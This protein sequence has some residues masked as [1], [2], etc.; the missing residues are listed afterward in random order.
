MVPPCVRC[1]SLNLACCTPVYAINPTYSLG[2]ILAPQIKE[3][4]HLSIPLSGY[5]CAWF[6][7]YDN[8]SCPL[9]QGFPIVATIDGFNPEAASEEEQLEFAGKE[10]VHIESGQVA[11]VLACL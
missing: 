11:L 2:Y 5:L 6:A 9:P 7:P 1:S 4:Q 3:S 8:L 10:D